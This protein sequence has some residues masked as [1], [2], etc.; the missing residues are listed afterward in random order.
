[1]RLYRLK[2]ALFL[3]LI[4]STHLIIGQSLPD[5]SSVNIS[6]LSDK[7][8]ELLIQRANAAGYSQQEL[9]QLAKGQGVSVE[10][11]AK[12]NNRITDF[13][14]KRVSPV[15]SSPIN[16]SRLRKAYRDSLDRVSTL[17]SEIFGLD[18]FS[19]SSL[20]S[21]QNSLNIPTPED[22]RLGPGDEL[23]IDVYGQ[24]E[25]YYQSEINPDGTIILENVGPI[26]ISGLSINQAKATV[27]RKLGA[28]YPGLIGD[29]P[30]TFLSISVGQLRTISISVV[31]AI[32]IPGT[33]SMS[34]LSTVFNALYNAGGVT[35][36]GTLRE[37]RVF[38]DNKL[39]SVIDVYDFLVNGNSK[40]N[41]RLENNDVV[42]VGPYTNR[43]TLL[44]AVKTPGKFELKENESLETLLGYAGGFSENAY[45]NSI[46]VNRIIDGERVIADVSSNQFEVFSPKAGDIFEVEE[47]LDRYK[48]RVIIKGAVF[49]P[50]NY[51]ITEQSTVK[52]IIEEGFAI[53]P[54]AF[55]NRAFILRTKEDL[56]TETISFDLGRLL[57]GDIPD[58]KLQKEDVLNI[59]SKN[60]LR[61]EKYI[62]IS[63]EVNNTGIFAYSEGMTLRDVILFAGGF[64]ESATGK[65]I[66][67]N[68]RVTDESEV[69]F[70]LSEVLIVD[71]DLNFLNT[72]SNASFSIEPFD[73]IVVRRNPNFH[74][75][76]FASI[77]GQVLYP[78]KYA[79]KNHGERI[80]D[81]LTRAGGLNNYAFAEGATLIRRTEFFEEETDIEQQIDD[82]V[83]L[84]KRLQIEP[85]TLTESEYL[86]IARVEENLTRLEEQNESN[87]SLSNFAKR[88]RLKEILEKN[89]LLGNSSF[90]Q[91]EA[92]GIKLDEILKRPGSPADLLLEEGDVLIIPKKTETVRLRG[93]LLYPTT[94]R[95]EEGRSLKHYINSAGGFD[96]RAKRNGT[97]VV[98]ANGSV[99]RTK[100]FLW[101]R[102]YPK[103]ARG[104]EIIV[105][106]KPLKIPLR[107]QDVVAVT[108]GLATLVLVVNQITS[109]N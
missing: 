67:I 72:G 83:E 52:S 63:G 35:E 58:I 106:A 8:L 69:N 11:I 96:N 2:W 13:K 49:R 6:E 79:I 53:R 27:R 23:F 91:A 14:S 75:Q 95:F 34:S 65:R 98:Y 19:N 42:I 15:S 43:V 59:L 109:S 57:K 24:S 41:I 1:M 101:F 90:K 82:L 104:A 55:L 88:E 32:R 73:H 40:G 33:Y 61:A 103:V 30:N 78:G 3:A 62:E 54:D 29:K 44:G 99:A 76:E 25:S 22:Y 80:S 86:M 68:R 87:Q 26:S 97:Y 38:R 10:D 84:Q 108:S 92:I 71:T 36:K 94:V 107:I 74:R 17:R 102:F 5:F 64:K 70:D 51:S 77:E 48:N 4:F 31:G 60:D 9:L 20:L 21:F 7:Q 89:S 45:S 85:E 28:V 50:G 18:V 46:K 66:D 105:P 39:V 37:I 47:V 81:I 12:L 100:K 56:S 16:D 93:K